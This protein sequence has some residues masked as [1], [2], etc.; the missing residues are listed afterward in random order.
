[1]TITP[2]VNSTTVAGVVGIVS[3]MTLLKYIMTSHRRIHVPTLPKIDVPPKFSDSDADIIVIGGGFT[4]ATFAARCGMDG[5]KVVMIEKNMGIDDTFR[6]EGL[7]PAGVNT[8]E[9]LGMKDVLDDV[10][11]NIITEYA[12]HDMRLGGKPAIV[13]LPEPGM[14]VMRHSSF[15]SALRNKVLSQQSVTV[16]EGVGKELL[17]ENGRVVGVKYRRKGQD[18][19]EE[20]R[21]PLVVVSDGHYPHLSNE[22]QTTY[23]PVSES[24]VLGL[25]LK[26]HEFGEGGGKHRADMIV[27]TSHAQYTV[28]YLN[29]HDIR[30]MV[31][32]NGPTPSDLNKF[33]EEKVAALAPD[34]MKESYLRSAKSVSRVQSVRTKSMAANVDSTP[35]V[36]VLGDAFNN[37]HPITACGMTVALKDVCYW[38]NALSN[39]KDLTDDKAIYEQKLHFHKERLDWAY[40]LNVIAEF[41][42]RLFSLNDESVIKMQQFMIKSLR[43]V[44]EEERSKPNPVS[45]LFGG[46]ITDPKA[47]NNMLDGTLQG[48]IQEIYDTQPYLYAVWEAMKV[49]RKWNAMMKE[50]MEPYA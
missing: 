18:N 6:G 49:R 22:F 7:L 3:A 8:L 2:S 26:D 38:W 47:V 29:K 39:V 34:H 1:M 11:G 24:F 4:G 44:P 12:F 19:L 48:T 25:L 28:Y 30:S 46:T 32:V 36:L 20:M 23:K 35:G 31:V 43:S 45:G 33:V 40:A 5:R 27:G 14:L 37:R 42:S 41:S 9:T 10:D 17:K 50:I 16:I 21:A 15:V 13:T